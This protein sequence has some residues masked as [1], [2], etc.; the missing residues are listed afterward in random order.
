MHKLLA[1][2]L[3]KC[4]G[5]EWESLNHSE[6]VQKLLKLVEQTYLQY[7]D[8]LRIQERML[9]VNSRELTEALK[10]VKKQHDLLHNVA[11]SV[12]DV[13][14]YKD[15]EFR[16]IGCN[17]A[18][19]EFMGISSEE[20][21]G[22]T[23]F[24]FFPPEYAS[25]FRERDKEVL[26]QMKTVVNTEWIKN[27]EDEA[28]L[29]VTTK[30]PLFNSSGECFGLV[31]VF[32]DIT[33]EHR[34]EAEIQSQQAMLIQQ[35]RLAAMGEMIGNIAHQW[36]QP[37][38]TLGLAVQDV[39]DAYFYGEITESYIEKFRTTAMEQINF[40][41]QTIDDFRNF[42]NPNKEKRYFLLEE[43][44]VSTLQILN[45]RLVKMGIT[46][47]VEI[48]KNLKMFGHQNEFTQVLFNLIKN[49]K[50]AFAQR[51]VDSPLIRIEA[52]CTPTSTKISVF[53]NAGGI[54]ETIRERIFDP[55]FTTKEEGKGTGIGL[56]MS[57]II[58]EKH[59]Q[60][61]LRHEP[62]PNG[63]VFIIDIPFQ[64]GGYEENCHGQ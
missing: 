44:V 36:R 21:V 13:I 51:D 53:D 1:L 12:N 4:F 10:N 3:R 19:E 58:I 64:K 35:S 7:D 17:R 61:T 32:R 46:Y 48:P 15:L 18:L 26:A 29:I 62:A 31:G 5:T 41:S 52:Q 24:D 34:M 22:K 28:V 59:M 9:E 39:E 38:N 33:K 49:A 57:K 56:Y 6:P 55:Y 54:E 25:I 11:D 20:L 27:A 8:D 50:D 37:L 45:P 23:D 43:S 42:F 14:F 40:M 16:F 60:G 47:H 30:T 2:Q 63:S